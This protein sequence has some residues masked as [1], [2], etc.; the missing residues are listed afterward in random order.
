MES[1]SNMSDNLSLQDDDTSFMLA[2]FDFSGDEIS[3]VF[4]AMSID[5]NTSVDGTH[6]ETTNNDPLP[7]EPTEH[8]I[9]SGRDPSTGRRTGNS[10]FRQMIDEKVYRTYTALRKPAKRPFCEALIKHIEGSV[11]RR[12]FLKR[13]AKT[14][15]YVVMSA[16]AKYNKVQK[17]LN[18]FG[19]ELQQRLLDESSQS[20]EAT[21]E[22]LRA[23]AD[24]LDQQDDQHPDAADALRQDGTTSLTIPVAGVHPKI[25]PMHGAAHSPPITSMV[26]IEVAKVSDHSHC[27]DRMGSLHTFS[28]GHDDEEDNSSA[29]TS[30]LSSYGEDIIFKEEDDGASTDMLTA[31]LSHLDEDAL[32]PSMH[33]QRFR[34]LS[35]IPP[36][37]QSP[38]IEQQPVRTVT[39]PYAEKASVSIPGVWSDMKGLIL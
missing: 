19:K 35:P 22:S 36:S 31:S 37:M 17:R 5:T 2:N 8:D 28:I 34:Q 27:L 1:H 12:R 4:S 7:I 14:G 25:Y 15:L 13:Q 24:A 9:V 11:P 16:Q 29:G 39:P 20:S 6:S 33:E 3:I 26:G 38:R 32:S 21:T 10:A 23:P 30:S 18:D